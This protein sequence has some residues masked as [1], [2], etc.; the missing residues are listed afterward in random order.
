MLLILQE[1]A[2]A[3][4][5]DLMT[6]LGEAKNGPFSTEDDG[7][8]GPPPNNDAT[9]KVDYQLVVSPTFIG[10]RIIGLV[11]SPMKTLLMGVDS[12]FKLPAGPITQ[13]G[14]AHFGPA[15][16]LSGPGGTPELWT[17]IFYDL[18]DCFGKRYH[19]YNK[20]KKQIFQPR[21]AIL[22]H[23]LCHAWHIQAGD[24]A[25]TV[26]GQEEQAINDENIGRQETSGS[27]LF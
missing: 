2:E 6:L 20:S 8:T 14:G 21:L 25:A 19:V 9:Y 18:G 26:A 16:F 4:Q 7:T 27:V 12:D 5:L 17:F 3:V 11:Q 10:N 24:A 13:Y 22:F 23:E 1:H 15:K